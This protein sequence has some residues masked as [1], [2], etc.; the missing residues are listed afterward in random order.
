M[1]TSTV[2]VKR[3]SEVLK[4]DRMGFSGGILYGCGSAGVSW[5]RCEDEAFPV[6]RVVDAFV[7]AAEMEAPLC[8]GPDYVLIGRGVKRLARSGWM[9]GAIG[10]T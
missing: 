2:K 6:F 3:N 10:A 9:S 5:L 1:S 7:L 8:G 4:S